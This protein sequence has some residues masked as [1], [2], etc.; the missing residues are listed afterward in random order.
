MAARFEVHRAFVVEDRGLFALAGRI[1]E[2]MVRVGM[3]ASLAG[4]EDAFT[5]PVHGVE[6]LEEEEGDAGGPSR[7]CLTFHCRDRE[8]LEAWTTL[9]WNGRTLRLRW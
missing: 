4:D 1:R 9:D 8:R 5:R 6:F 2:G 7:P 3:T